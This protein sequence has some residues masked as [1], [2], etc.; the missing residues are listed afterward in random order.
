MI[1]RKAK[2]DDISALCRLLREVL[3]VHN[4][5]RP[6]IFKP[7]AQKY[8]E[9]ELIS[10]LADENRPVFVAEREGEVVGY[11]F[12][13]IKQIEN[14]NILRDMKTLYVDDLCVDSAARG[15]G[16]GRALMDFVTEHARTL[17]CYNITL[18]VWAQNEGAVG[19]YEKLGLTPQ[20][21]GL[22]KILE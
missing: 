21:I 22:E 9:A 12:C 1:I 5:A 2:N 16:I 6:D 4:K 18:N 13:I 10:I 7:N 15:A 8:T 3:G 19:F 17:G 11:A 14:D 20:K